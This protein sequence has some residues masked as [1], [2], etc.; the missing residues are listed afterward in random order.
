[1]HDE[2]APTAHAGLL[3]E[4]SAVLTALWFEIDHRD[5][6]EA[7][8]FFTEEADLTFSRR[9]FHGRSEID[10][11]YR[12]RAARGPRVSRHVVTNVHVRDLG[13]GHAESVSVLVL[14]A[15]DGEP[16]ITT[17]TPVMIADV[18]DR[19]VAVPGE[20]DEPRRWMIAS[21]RIDSCFLAP[22]DVLAVPTE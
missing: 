5:G 13:P 11:V 21:R 15:Q 3:A 9:T 12:A 6:A 1:M 8:G 10:E 20:K 17:T 18:H 19:F 4:L 7:S 16:P 22:G 2:H 14:Y